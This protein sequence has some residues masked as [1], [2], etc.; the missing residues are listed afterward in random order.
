MFCKNT[1]YKGRT[2]I[3]DIITIDDN[4]RKAVMDGKLNQQTVQQ[5]EKKQGNLRRQAMKKVLTGITTWQEVKRVVS[6]V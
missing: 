3:Y 2:G 4:I 1:G 6:S 5:Y